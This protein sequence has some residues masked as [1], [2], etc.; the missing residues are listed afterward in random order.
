MSNLSDAEIGFKVIREDRL[1]CGCI[2]L[3]FLGDQAKTHKSFTS[4][5]QELLSEAMK[6]FALDDPVFMHYLR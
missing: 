5:H 3:I 6:G 1:L 2:N 4:S